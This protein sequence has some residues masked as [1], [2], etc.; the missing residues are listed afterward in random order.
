MNPLPWIVPGPLHAVLACIVLVLVLYRRRSR[1]S[2][3]WRRLGVAALVWSWLGS[4]P[5]LGNLWVRALEDRHAA[6]SAS[7]LTRSP[8][9]VIVVLASGQMFRPDGSLALALDVDGWERLLAGIA[10]WRQIGGTLV[11]A[12]GPDHGASDSLAHLMRRAALDAAVPT[13]AVIT[14]GGGRNTYEDLRAVAASLQA[15]QR[16]GGPGKL[17]GAEPV[18][19]ETG[20]TWLVTSALHMPRAMG[21]AAALGLPVTAAPCCFR[22]LRPP[23]WRAWLPDNGDSSLWRDGLH[24]A[25]GLEV[26]RWRGWLR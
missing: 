8:S 15:L 6:P 14:A 2:A 17:G 3:G 12:G 7:L 5:A 25:L 23:T 1:V 26:Y 19:T 24:E 21:T 16:P 10:L 9:N 13:S 22:Q 20:R 4:T 18:A 11:M